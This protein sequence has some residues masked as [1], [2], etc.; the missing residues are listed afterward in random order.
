MLS[1]EAGEGKSRMSHEMANEL[2]LLGFRVMV[3]RYKESDADDEFL[4]EEA[5]YPIDREF[6]NTQSVHDL[7]GSRFNLRAYDFVFIEIPALLQSRYPVD[8]LEGMD[9]AVMA[10]KASR[11][12]RKADAHA[13]EEVQKVLNVVPRVALNGVDP[14]DMEE[15]IGEVAKRRSEFSKLIRK[16]FTFELSTRRGY[17]G[18]PMF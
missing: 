18:Q 16:A 11:V 3:L 2:T 14:E 15:I 1:T 9:C 4:Y 7:V 6:L 5:M 12:W 10:I 17:K 8:L 13:L